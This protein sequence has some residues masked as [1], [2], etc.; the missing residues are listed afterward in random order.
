MTLGSTQPLPE[1]STGN[2]P[3]GK[4]QPARRLETL[5]PFVSRLFRECDSLNVLQ[6]YGP[7]RPPTEI[8]EITF[9][10]KVYAR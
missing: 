9:T 7:P 4:G 2:L 3:R 8:A 5:P 10:T 1:M 6:P